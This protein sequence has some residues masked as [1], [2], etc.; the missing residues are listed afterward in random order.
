MSS[1]GCVVSGGHEV[2][3][4]QESLDDA[5]SLLGI[6]LASD[7]TH[8]T[9]QGG[10]KHVHPMSLANILKAT[11]NKQSKRGWMVQVRLEKPTFAMYGLSATNASQA[12]KEQTPG[13]LRR[14][15]FHRAMRK[16]FEP[17]RNLD[18]AHPVE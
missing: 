13:I 1:L 6:V 11:R 17:L 14:M 2:C 18:P 4:K 3:P 8:I 5:I 15:A 16:V 12:Q 9:N 10:N 7:A